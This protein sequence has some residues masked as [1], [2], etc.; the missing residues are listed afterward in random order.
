[1]IIGGDSSLESPAEKQG[2]M[3]IQVQVPNVA[4][5]SLPVRES[6][7]CAD[8]L[9]LTMTMAVPPPPPQPHVQSYAPKSVHTL[10]IPSTSC[11]TI[12]WV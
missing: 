1:M 10:K 4:K 6:T 2:L 9:S 11:H 3:L 12:T 7:S 8:F 5:D